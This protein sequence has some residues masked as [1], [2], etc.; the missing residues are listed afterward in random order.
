MKTHWLYRYIGKY[1]DGLMMR[2]NGGRGDGEEEASCR[3]QKKPGRGRPNLVWQCRQNF[4]MQGAMLLGPQKI[5][6]KWGCPNS[7][8]SDVLD[9]DLT[10]SVF[11]GYCQYNCIFQESVFGGR[12][13]KTDFYRIFDIIQNIRKIKK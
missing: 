9:T 8:Q 1:Q 12:H 5:P 7:T 11:G 13:R 6:W 3:G 4:G 10:I 2:K